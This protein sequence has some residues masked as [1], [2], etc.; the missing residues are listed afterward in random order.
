MHNRKD[1]AKREL[2]K[3]HSV[4]SLEGSYKSHRSD[5]TL[6]ET[7]MVC[8][9]NG[10]FEVFSNQGAPAFEEEIQFHPPANFHTI[11]S[12]ELPKEKPTET[13]TRRWK[14]LV[15]RTLPAIDLIDLSNEKDP[16]CAMKV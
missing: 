5:S 7:N 14:D 12:P 2:V 13:M 10:N 9:A 15:E 1:M 6:A 11:S 8:S 4:M 16:Y 3:N